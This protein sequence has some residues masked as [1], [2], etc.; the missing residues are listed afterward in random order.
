MHDMI[1]DVSIMKAK[2][3]MRF[4]IYRPDR[5]SECLDNPR[6]RVVF[7]VN[8]GVEKFNH[9][10]HQNKHIRSLFFQ[11][12]NYIQIDKRQS[13]W[14]S[15]QLLQLLDFEGF[16]MTDVP[17]AVGLLTELKY[18]GLTSSDSYTISNQA[19][20]HLTKSYEINKPWNSI[21]ILEFVKSM[22]MIP[23]VM[24]AYRILLTIFV[25]VASGEM[26]FFKLKLLKSYLRTQ[27]LKKG[28]MH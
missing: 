16:K 25:T 21:K 14:K 2:K 24:I 9:S 12:Y 4:D 28:L 10:E 1:H 17:D 11:G 26:S 23:N 13:Y 3:E 18:L 20:A 22:D 27:W 19:L 15:F 8:G 7:C 5:K 6:H